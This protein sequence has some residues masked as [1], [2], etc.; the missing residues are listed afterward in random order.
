ML[1]TERVICIIN[2]FETLKRVLAK[3][4]NKKAIQKKE[5][6]NVILNFIKIK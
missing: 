4:S 5:F 3:S 2:I 6:L 1:Y